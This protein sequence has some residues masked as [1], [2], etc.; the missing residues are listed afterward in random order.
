MNSSFVQG[1]R[2]LGSSLAKNRG[3]NPRW[4]KFFLNFIIYFIKKVKNYNKI[5][6]NKNK[7]LII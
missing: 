2:T 6:V 4:G 5:I 1:V 3:S 7:Y